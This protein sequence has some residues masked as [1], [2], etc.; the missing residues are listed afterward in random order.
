MDSYLCRCIVS[1][2]FNVAFILGDFIG[3]R[4]VIQ[5]RGQ[6]MCNLPLFL[7]VRTHVEFVSVCEKMKDR[8]LTEQSRTE[9][10]M[11]SEK[12]TNYG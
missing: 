3:L 2:K 5:L 12:K 4:A 11:F 9:K 1:S 10:W 6:I 7:V 8:M